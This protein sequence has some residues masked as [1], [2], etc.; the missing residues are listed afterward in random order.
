MSITCIINILPAL[1]DLIDPVENLE[2][3]KFMITQR[4]PTCNETLAALL[5]DNADV[6]ATLITFIARMSVQDAV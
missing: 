5:E 4:T 2:R 1:L 3:R 6:S